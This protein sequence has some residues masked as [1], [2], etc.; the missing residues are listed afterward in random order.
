MGQHDSRVNRLTNHLTP[1]GPK[2]PILVRR[3]QTEPVIQ[4]QPPLGDAE[5]IAEEQRHRQFV[6]ERRYSQGVCSLL[7]YVQLPFE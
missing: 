6:I 2:T 5:G 4:K 1:A 3:I 7:D